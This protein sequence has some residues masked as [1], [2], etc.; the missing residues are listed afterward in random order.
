LITGLNTLSSKSAIGLARIADDAA[1][2]AMAAVV[3]ATCAEGKYCA[4][5]GISSQRV[6]HTNSPFTV[7]SSYP[8]TLS[9]WFCAT[10]PTRKAFGPGQGGATSAFTSGAAS[11]GISGGAGVYGGL[12]FGGFGGGCSY[13]NS[14]GL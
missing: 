7:C 2:T 1:V 9:F 11:F 5:M 6:T 10:S 13:C 3:V 12:T 14:S 8:D 4:T